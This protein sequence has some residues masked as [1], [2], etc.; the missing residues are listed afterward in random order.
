MAGF[1]P[2]G[3]VLVLGAGASA[4]AGYPLA[5]RLLTFIR[6]Y[7]FSEMRTRER[8]SRVIAKLN[9][10]EFHFTREVV[11]DPNGVANLEELL[12]YLEM[13]HSFPGTPFSINPWNSSDSADIRSVVTS[14]FLEHQ[15]DLNRTTWGDGT[16]RGTVG[17][18]SAAWASL[19][20]PGDVILTF[21]WD[22][23]HEVI[24]WRHD[25]WSYRDGYGFKF[26]EQGQAERSSG[27]LM[28]KLHGS[29]N[30][31]QQNDGDSVGHIADAKDFFSGSKDWDWRPHD[32]E[33]QA[34]SGRKLVLPTYLKDISSNKVLLDVWT[35][36]HRVIRDA[37]EMIVV[38]YSLNAVDHPARLLF[39]TALS[40][41]ASLGC[42][43]VVSPD[44]GEWGEFLSRIN[45]RVSPVR[46]KFEDWVCSAGRT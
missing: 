27:T 28:L 26:D 3:R 29:V 25:L 7:T 44:T 35:K 41:N 22:I 43:T 36:A 39:G 10:A 21:N 18:V 5:P 20:R 23:L 34:D 40:E 12:T 45:K 11:R 6:N 24:L 2:N 17:E 46:Q 9:E 15:Y 8:A 14:R 13:Y 31:V 38:G 33:A 32:N 37:R 1:V 19:I 42:V 16:A 30:W 4:Y